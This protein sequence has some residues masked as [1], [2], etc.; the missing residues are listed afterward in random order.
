VPTTQCD[1]LM[2]REQLDATARTSVPTTWSSGNEGK[3]LLFAPT[4]WCCG[5]DTLCLRCQII[6]ERP[7]WCRRN[8]AEMSLFVLTTWYRGN[9][10]CIGNFMSWER[11]WDV[12]VC[13]NKLMPQERHSLFALPTHVGM[14]NIP[15]N[16]QSTFV[17]TLAATSALSPAGHS[18]QTYHQ[19]HTLRNQFIVAF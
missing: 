12:F 6:W 19:T 3:L 15:S 9:G 4:T 14:P 18:H 16:P 1:N 13:T 10:I 5:N 7:C 17:S 11:R 2:L 8:N